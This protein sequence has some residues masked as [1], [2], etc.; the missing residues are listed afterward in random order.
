MFLSSITWIKSLKINKKGRNKF[1]EVYCK[2][3][4]C[5]VCHAEAHWVSMT[6]SNA[7]NL[8]SERRAYFNF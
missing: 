2:C 1:D 4:S 3:D 6:R 5:I 8:D 7:A